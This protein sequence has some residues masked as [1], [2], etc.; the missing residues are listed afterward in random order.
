VRC[1]WR[2]APEKCIVCARRRKSSSRFASV[3]I[4]A[5]IVGRLTGWWRAA[6]AGGRSRPRASHRSCAIAAHRCRAARRALHRRGAACR[7]PVPVRRESGG[8]A[9]HAPCRAV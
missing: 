1:R 4:F 3:S 8:F 7:A 2:A 5:C 9:R 6:E